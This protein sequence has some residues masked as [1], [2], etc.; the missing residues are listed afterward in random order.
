MSEAK[1][2]TGSCHC[3]AIRFETTLDASKGTA[4]NCSIC[5]R[6]GAIMAF[7]TEDH[8]KLLSGKEAMKDY[9]FAKKHI[10]HQFCSHCG[11]R[12]FGHGVGPGGKEMFSVNLR[13]LEDIDVSKI[14]VSHFDGKSLKSL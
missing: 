9:Q 5:G 4:C 1:T 13:C 14:E 11:V 12:P 6:S 2:Y 3:G 8:L 10:H 7:V